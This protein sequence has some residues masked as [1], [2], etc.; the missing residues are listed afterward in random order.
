MTMDRQAFEVADDLLYHTGKALVSGDFDRYAACFA[1][2]YS[3][4][5]KD[6]KRTV[7]TIG[8]LRTV[9]DEVRAHMHRHGVD[10][11]VRTII[12]ADLVSKDV[13]GRTHVSQMIQPD[14]T[15]VL[16]PYPSYSVIRRIDGVWRTASSIHAII[17]DPKLANALVTET[18]QME[19][20]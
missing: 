9:F 3:L 14:G 19:N 20:D 6:T 10:E 8:D 15:P 13:I 16:P 11:I 17:C 7:R 12:S 18:G 4:E 2:P 1:V 5:T